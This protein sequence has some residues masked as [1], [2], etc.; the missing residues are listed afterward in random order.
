MNDRFDKD[1]GMK[2][3]IRQ[4]KSI[5]DASAGAN[6]FTQLFNASIRAKGS[7]K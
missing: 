2:R 4:R 3:E 6:Q 1:E 7:A 5:K